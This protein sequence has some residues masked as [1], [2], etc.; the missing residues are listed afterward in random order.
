M[1]AESGVRRGCARRELKS[2]VRA[3]Y[4]WQCKKLDTLNISQGGS[5]G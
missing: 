2:T 3:V 4:L 5:G 1:G